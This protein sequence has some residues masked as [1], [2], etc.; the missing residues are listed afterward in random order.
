MAPTLTLHILPPSHPCKTVEA[1]LRVKGLD[2][3]IVTM[4]AGAHNDELEAIYGAGNRTVPGML[5]DGEPDG[6]DPVVPPRL[7]DVR[8]REVGPGGVERRSV[9]AG[10]RPHRFGAEV[11]GAPRQAAPEVLQ[12]V[13]APALGL[14]H[15]A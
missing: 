5:V 4:T 9:R 7:A 1:A 11:E 10:E 15:G 12:L 6:R 14:A 3:E 8:H 13:V 2:A